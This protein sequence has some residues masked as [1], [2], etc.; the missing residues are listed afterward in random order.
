MQIRISKDKYRGV[1][2]GDVDWLPDLPSG[3]IHCSISTHN[4]ATKKQAEAALKKLIAELITELE[5]H[6]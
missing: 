2:D 1:Y 4:H 5:K 3:V 6:K